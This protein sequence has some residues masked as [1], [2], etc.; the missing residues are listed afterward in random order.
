LRVFSQSGKYLRE[1]GNRDM[2]VGLP[3]ASIYLN[4]DSVREVDELFVR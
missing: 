3:V 2:L 1:D 4:P